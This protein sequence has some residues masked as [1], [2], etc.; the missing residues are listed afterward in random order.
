[1]SMQMN[2]YLITQLSGQT[3]DIPIKSKV[4]EVSIYSNSLCL[5][6]QEDDT[7]PTTER[8]FHTI[9][10]RAAIPMDWLYQGMVLHPSTGVALFVFEEF[11]W[12]KCP[13]LRDEVD[14]LMR[15][16]RALNREIEELL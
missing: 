5:Y 13:S 14:R 4:L 11:D 6:V 3:F 2:R 12:E 9:N 15:I 7:T 1:M 16:N 8:T 10:D